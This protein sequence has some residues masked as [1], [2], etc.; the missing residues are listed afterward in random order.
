MNFFDD[1]RIFSWW[2]CEYNLIW[3]YFKNLNDMQKAEK[4]LQNRYSQINFQ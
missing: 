2:Y 3:F 4:L 1:M